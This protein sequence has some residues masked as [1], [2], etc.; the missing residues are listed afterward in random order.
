MFFQW[1][2]WMGLTQKN[3]IWGESMS[4]PYHID[5]SSIALE[6]GKKDSSWSQLTCN[7][8]WVIQV[9][10]VMYQV[11]NFFPA[12]AFFMIRI[13][14]A[15][16]GSP[17]LFIRPLPCHPRPW[18]AKLTP[19]LASKRG[20]TQQWLFHRWNFAPST[21]RLSKKSWRPA[22][23]FMVYCSKLNQIGHHKLI[24]QVPG[25]GCI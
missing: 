18:R 4:H 1:L 3:G 17:L 9:R 7:I 12:V 23:P 15:S 24:C 16:G 6:I 10:I 2:L 25:T 14:I 20:R 5:R 11:D 8:F 13:S 22:T 19:A 21:K